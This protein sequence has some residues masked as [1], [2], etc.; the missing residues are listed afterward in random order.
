M[1]NI[2][3]NEAIPVTE[4]NWS[5]DVQPVVTVF[6]WSYNHVNFIRQSIESI[7]QQK[8]TFHIEIIIHDDA[9]NDGTIEI[10]REYE[11]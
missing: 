3:L 4:Q 6:N 2:F 9:S 5:D 8:T 10:I 1:S 11:S 7:L